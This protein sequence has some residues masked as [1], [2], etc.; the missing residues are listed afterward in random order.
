MAG[1]ITTKYG[2]SNQ[3]ITVTL[4]SL[5]NNSSRESTAIDNSSNLFLDALVGGKIKSPASATATTG[6]VAVYAYGTTDGG[7]TYSDTASGTDAA[8]TL[9]VPPNAKLIGII[10]VV[11]NAVTYEFGPFSV[12]SAF[13]GVLPDHWGLIFENKTGGTLDT[14]GSNHA[15]HYQGIKGAYT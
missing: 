15:V 5:A 6:I 8:I 7:T 13:G 2:S 4:A 10:N 11:A 1:D 9:T 14:T 12:A 3:A